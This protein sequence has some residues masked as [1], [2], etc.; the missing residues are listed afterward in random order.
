MSKV[1]DESD[2]K[3]DPNNLMNSAHKA[4][5]QKYRDMYDRIFRGKKST[6]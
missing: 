3:P 5:N 2:K 1:K 6:K 4:T